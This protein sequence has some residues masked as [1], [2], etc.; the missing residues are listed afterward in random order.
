LNCG[1]LVEPRAPILNDNIPVG[2]LVEIKKGVED[3]DLPPDRIGL[4]VKANEKEGIYH[5]L[6]SNGRRLQF[7]SYWLTT[8]NVA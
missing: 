5:V 6:L 7:N 1:W 3:D 2:A 4:I 8:L